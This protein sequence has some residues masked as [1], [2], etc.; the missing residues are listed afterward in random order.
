MYLLTKHLFGQSVF[1]TDLEQTPFFLKSDLKI[2]DFT[3]LLHFLITYIF[4]D[5]QQKYIFHCPYLFC[6]LFFF[7]LELFII[8]IYQLKVNNKNTGTRS[9]ICSK[10]TIKAPEQCQWCRSS[11]FIVNFEHI[12]YLVLMFGLLTLNK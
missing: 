9:E 6:F 12:L 7:L 1:A 11:V 8:S 10:L 5:I 3:V 2:N 4:N